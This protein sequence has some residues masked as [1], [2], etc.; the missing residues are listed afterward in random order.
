M[1]QHDCDCI[2]LRCLRS[3]KGKN[4][5]LCPW[6]F[7]KE[8]G[9][10][11]SRDCAECPRAVVVTPSGQLSTIME[12]RRETWFLMHFGCDLL[13]LRR[14]GEVFVGECWRGPGTRT[15]PKPCS[16]EDCPL[17]KGEGSE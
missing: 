12:V 8:C 11:D 17:M 3:R 4:Y 15:E 14:E 2:C 1:K 6:W 13:I 7:Q 10:Y 16:F 9:E 5:Q